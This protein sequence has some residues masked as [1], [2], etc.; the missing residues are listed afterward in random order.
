MTTDAAASSTVPSV[1]Q[2]EIDALYQR[3]A[4]TSL[5]ELVP[6]AQAAPG[7]SQ[8]R[9]TSLLQRWR[10]GFDWAAVEQQLVDLGHKIV[11]T[12]DGR[13]L[14][15]LHCRAKN[16][17]S[18]V[19]TDSTA[20]PKIPVL[21]VH[22]WP[23]S[24]LRFAELI[25]RLTTAGHDVV[26]PAIPG[27]GWSQEP[28][29][30][31]SRDLAAADFHELMTSLG[32]ERYAVHG[33]DWGSAVA[34]TIAQQHAEHVVAVHLTDVPFDLAFTIDPDSASE[35]E[36]AYLKTVEAFADSALYLYA[37]SLQPNLF[38]T[39]LADSPIGL[40]AW[41]G[42]L[43]DAWSQRA[44]DDDVILANAAL[45]WFT[46]T[47]RSSMR[48]YSEPANDWSTEDWPADS[49]AT[50]E[51]GSAALAGSE[52]QDTA[53]AD[54]STAGSDDAA[55]S[56]DWSWAPEPVTV[57]TAFALFPGDLVGTAP[58]QLADKHFAVERFTVMPHSGHFAALEEPELLASD[59][60]E[61]LADK[62]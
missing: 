45:M 1:P 29:G 4:A 17:E 26:A 34:T 16:T 39:L 8:D 13:D 62:K 12:S 5:P 47:A 27:F 15:T 23:D 30:P 41:L 60:I 10:E 48:L 36:A 25:P 22:G 33:G 11:K 37:N 38:A 58:R 49:T 57:P 28:E 14:W 55:G 56:D 18:I 42:A 61:F 7:P 53:D 54:S 6:S 51:W 9:A 40:A 2:Q 43:Y 3:L 44:L 52:A 20:S 31:M 59:M 24:P 50:G 32:Y 19:N 21:L 46:K 35:A